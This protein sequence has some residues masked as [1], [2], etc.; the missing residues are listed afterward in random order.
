MS[1]ITNRVAR[2]FTSRQ[3]NQARREILK[4]LDDFCARLTAVLDGELKCNGQVLRGEFD[5]LR[6][7]AESLILF[8]QC[9]E[10]GSTRE[11]AIRSFQSAWNQ[12]MLDK[13]HKAL[14]LVFSPDQ[15][16]LV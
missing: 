11:L 15:L 12:R 5:L 9:Y 2:A 10:V 8:G 13:K 4:E 6:T 1:N 14:R 7:C 3:I 16:I